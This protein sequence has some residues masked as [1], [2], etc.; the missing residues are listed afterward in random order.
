MVLVS[1]VLHVGLGVFWAGTLFFMVFLLD[2]SIRSVGPD[3]GKVMQA[4]QKR[5]FHNIMPIVAVLTVLSGG[6]LYGRM[7]A[8]AGVAWIRSPFG[9]T[10]T[11]GAIAALLAL[12]EGVVFM[13]P[14]TVKTGRL[15]ASLGG[16]ADPAEREALM[17]EIKGLSERIRAHLRW[18][19]VWLFIAVLAMALGRY[20]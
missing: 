2:P 5:G 16:V 17:A 13:R 19:A 1:R 10:I 14:I 20:I 9:V 15:A 3:G 7:V 18:I 11:I 6:Y 8:G 12:G 4:L